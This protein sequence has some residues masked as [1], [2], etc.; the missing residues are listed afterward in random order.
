MI[1]L[2]EEGLKEAPVYVPR[3]YRRDKYH[4]KSAMELEVLKL[5]EISQMKSGME[6]FKLRVLENLPQMEDLENEISTFVTR[7]V[8]DPL[9]RAEVLKNWESR[10]RN[11]IDIC[12]QY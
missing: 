12:N 11:L 9:V 2:N 10:K 5:V 7:T 1:K 8:Q 4:I 6:I 3:Q